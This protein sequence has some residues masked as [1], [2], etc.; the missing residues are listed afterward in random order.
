MRITKF[1]DRRQTVD[2][3]RFFFRQKSL[4]IDKKF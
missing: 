1:A 2:R 4:F 3:R